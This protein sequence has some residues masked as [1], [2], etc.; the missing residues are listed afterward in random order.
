MMKLWDWISQQL[1]PLFG[2]LPQVELNL[3]NFGTLSIENI[4]QMMFWLAIGYVMVQVLVLL[5]YD[6]VMHLMRR[7]GWRK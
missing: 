4:I 5:P 6:W 1:L 2:E 7:K 3:G